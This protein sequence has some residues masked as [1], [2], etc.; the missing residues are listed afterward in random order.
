MRYN[1]AYDRIRSHIKAEGEGWAYDFS[2][3]FD[4]DEALYIDP[5]HVSA[6][7]NEII[8]ERMAEIRGIGAFRSRRL[9]HERGD[10]P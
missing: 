4:G 2:F 3:A 5:F 9:T 6:R 10:E 7:G 8:A 1:R